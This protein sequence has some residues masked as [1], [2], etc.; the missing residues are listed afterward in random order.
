MNKVRGNRSQQI[1]PDWSVTNCSVPQIANVWANEAKDQGCGT[2]NRRGCNGAAHRERRR[3]VAA[4]DL[5][6]GMANRRRFDG[7]AHCK[8]ISRQSRFK[9]ALRNRKFPP[10]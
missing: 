5:G 9:T 2:A 1:T 10:F 3:I 8:T 6:C 4:Q 7:D